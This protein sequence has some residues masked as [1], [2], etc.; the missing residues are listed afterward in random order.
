MTVT[1]VMAA[2]DVCDSE[3]A[4]EISCLQ[5]YT[6]G[7]PIHVCKDCGFVYVRERRSFREIADEWSEVIFATG[8]ST[9]RAAEVYTAVRPAIRARLIQ[10]LETIDQELGLEGKKLCDIG[11]GEG[12][13]LNYAKQLKKCDELF[14]I[15]PSRANCDL[16]GSLG[17]PSFAGTIEDYIESAEIEKEAFDVAAIQW[18]LECSPESSRMLEGV[19]EVLKPKGHVVVA[20]GSRILV[21]FRKPLQFYVSSGSQDTHCLRFSANSLANLLR[22]SGFEPVFVNRYIDN[23]IM[24][25]I[26]QKSDAPNSTE[27]IADDYREVIEFFERWD[28]ETGEHYNNLV[29]D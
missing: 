15:E 13:F 28:Q 27:I 21:P 19:R 9:N 12:V 14:G 18:T 10:V 11:A 2:C 3:D 25:M 17:I 1:G 26:G 24:C 7:Q 20:T 29:D 5:K 8:E 4:V 16:M 23:D 22:R 6:G